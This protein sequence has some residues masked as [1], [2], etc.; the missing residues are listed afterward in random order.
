M[1]YT[2]N[3]VV[4][5]VVVVVVVGWKG[6]VEVRGVGVTQRGVVALACSPRYFVVPRG[7]ELSLEEDAPSGLQR[8][9]LCAETP[10]Q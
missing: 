9:I 2:F 7:T 1:D 8:K 3:I 4:V 10:T 5:V 6:P